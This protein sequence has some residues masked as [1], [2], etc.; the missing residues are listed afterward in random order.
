GSNVFLMKNGSI[1]K[2]NIGCGLH[3]ASSHPDGA[4]RASDDLAIPETRGRPRQGGLHGAQLRHSRGGPSSRSTSLYRGP[5]QR[6][7]TK[8]GLHGDVAIRT[9]TETLDAVAFTAAPSIAGLSKWP[10]PRSFSESYTGPSDPCVK[11]PLNFGE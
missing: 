3:Q 4:S 11:L 2:G 6:D 10:T 9:T 8:G 5:N 1:H 7:R